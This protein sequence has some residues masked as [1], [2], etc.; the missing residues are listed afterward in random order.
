M[1]PRHAF[2]A[3]AFVLLSAPQFYATVPANIRGIVHDPTHRPS[4]GAQVTLRAPA[5]GW[6]QRAQSNANG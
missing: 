4:P 3:V 5:S 2:F 1:R 6:T